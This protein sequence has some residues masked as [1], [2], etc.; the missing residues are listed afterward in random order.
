MW[1][2]TGRVAPQVLFA[3]GTVSFSSFSG[4]D[5]EVGKRNEEPAQTTAQKRSWITMTPGGERFHTVGNTHERLPVTDL[6]VVKATDPLTND[7][8]PGSPVALKS[9]PGMPL[10]TNSAPL[11]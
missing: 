8:R 9:S 2:L 6:L 5:S 11:R 3:D 10:F 1:Q 4:P 7:V